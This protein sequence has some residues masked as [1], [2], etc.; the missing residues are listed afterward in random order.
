[1]SLTIQSED[2]SE[3]EGQEES[4]FHGRRDSPSRREAGDKGDRSNGVEGS[5]G[6]RLS[7]RRQQ[8]QGL[9]DL[10]LGVTQRQQ[11][12]RSRMAGKGEDE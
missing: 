4:L 8:Q 2:E 3:R 11:H 1:M 7:L 12:K 9:S 6:A 5:S 10:S